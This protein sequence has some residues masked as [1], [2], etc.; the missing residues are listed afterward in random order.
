MSLK[1]ISVF[2]ENRPGTLKDM[3]AVLTE[4]RI[5][6]RALSLAETKDFG[7][8]R[9]I[10]DDAY[11]AANVLKDAGFVSSLTSVVG[12]MIP[13]GWTAC[14]RFCKRIMSTW[15]ICMRFWGE[16]KSTTPI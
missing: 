4:N 11:H 6:M 5:D 14:W 3:T 8:A 12:V 16:R 7:I 10:V 15:N 13:E 2:L 9:L 1:Q